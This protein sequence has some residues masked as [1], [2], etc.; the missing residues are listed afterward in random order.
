MNNPNLPAT[1]PNH[2]KPMT[3]AVTQNQQ[4][5]VQIKGRAQT[6]ISLIKPRDL[7]SIAEQTKQ[8]AELNPESFYYFFTFYSE[9]DQ[10]YV[11]V[12]D[13]SIGGAR[14]LMQ[15]YGNCTV[16]QDPMQVV[17]EKHILS[18]VFIDY[19][20]N[21]VIPR[22]YLWAQ[23]KVS[24][25]YQAERAEE[26]AFSSAYSKWLRN[27]IVGGIP[28]PLI[29]LALKT[30]KGAHHEAIQNQITAK[31]HAQ[32][33]KSYLDRL[34]AHKIP[35]HMLKQRYA[36][37]DPA[38]IPISVLAMMETDLVVLDSGEM[39]V[40]DIFVIEPVKNTPAPIQSAV[41]A[42][43]QRMGMEPPPVAAPVAEPPKADPNAQNSELQ[44][45]QKNVAVFLNLMN[46]APES[47][48]FVGGYFIETFALNIDQEPFETWT[49]KIPPDQYQKVL[50]SLGTIIKTKG[51][52]K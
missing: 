2:L 47:K 5:A 12:S 49:A 7:R 41:T 18:G 16:E 44:K 19:E 30:A 27:T 46:Q 14:T 25:G 1:Q 28:E 11:I 10:K 36:F 22:Q 39:S 9:K 23:R 15:L 26:M 8:L 42:A 13:L 51:N 40:A 52:K 38:A 45:F 20:R 17:G 3:Q 21:V 34:T 32:V 37:G 50:S 29:Q 48:R 4:A 43:K 24:G 33:S 31:G 35:D 6:Q